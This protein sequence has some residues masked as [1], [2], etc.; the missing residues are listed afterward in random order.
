[1]IEQPDQAEALR[2]RAQYPAAAEEQMSRSPRSG[3]LPLIADLKNTV[4]FGA[5]RNSSS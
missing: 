3:T 2:D 4:C 1:V 5:N